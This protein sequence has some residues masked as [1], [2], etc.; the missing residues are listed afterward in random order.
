[1]DLLYKEVRNCHWSG[2]HKK[3]NKMPNVKSF[4]FILLVE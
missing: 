4:H 2:L 1:M 3:Q